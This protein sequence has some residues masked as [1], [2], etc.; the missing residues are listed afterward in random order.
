MTSMTGTHFLL[1]SA[2]SDTLGTTSTAAQDIKNIAESTKDISSSGGFSGV[3]AFFE[4]AMPYIRSLVL[5]LIVCLIIYLVGRKVIKVLM[6][7]FQKLLAKS[8]IEVGASRF[9][10]SAAKVALYIVMIFMIVGQLG[11]NTASIVTL[12]GTVGVAIGLSLQGSLSNVAGGIL[13]LFT[14]PFRVEDYIT[15]TYGEGTVKMIGLAY[16]TIVTPDNK[17]ITVPNSLLTSTAVTDITANPQRR[18]DITVGIGYDDDIRK[19][20]EI[21]SDIVESYP[22]TV[23]SEGKEPKVYVDSLGD[24]SVV[25]GV[26]LWV[27]TPDYLSSKWDITESIKN[28]LDEAGIGIPYPQM[29]VHLHQS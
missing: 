18:L 21:L 26:Q 23:H 7:M 6:N 14:H 2:A 1:L 9:L 13:L 12:L 24:S 20:K 4:A 27:P 17:V 16:T 29:D 5:N 10:V 3:T 8:K 28:R 11:I 25:M 22:K 15:C 19:T